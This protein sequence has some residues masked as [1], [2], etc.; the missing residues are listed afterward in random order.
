MKISML[1]IKKLN[2]LKFTIKFIFICYLRINIIFVHN[3]IIYK[4][5]FLSMLSFIIMF[6]NQ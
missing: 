2:I 5:L 3:C 4:T 6:Y 1:K